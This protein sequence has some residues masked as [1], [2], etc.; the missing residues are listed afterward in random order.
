MLLIIISILVCLLIAGILFSPIVFVVNTNSNEYFLSLQGFIR[1]QLTKIEET[2]RIK[3]KLFFL[4][5]TMNPFRYKR[6]KKIKN[7]K[8][9]SGKTKNPQ[10]IINA[11]R[12]AF[13]AITIKKL[14]ANIDTG[15]YP[16]NAQLLAVTPILNQR[17]ISLNVNFESYNTIEFKAITYIYK[18]IGIAIALYITKK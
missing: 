3:L 14:I 13:K 2:W 7:E 16:L 17:N 5:F 18:L 6:I 10:K 9:K 4:S 11:I 12:K 8:T 1:I 15:N